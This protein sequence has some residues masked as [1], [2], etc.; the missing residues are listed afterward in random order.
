MGR[1]LGGVCKFRI[2]DR[3]TGWKIR[4]LHKSLFL[5]MAL[6]ASITLLVPLILG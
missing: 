3:F 2:H 6:F 1:G 4:R 5:K